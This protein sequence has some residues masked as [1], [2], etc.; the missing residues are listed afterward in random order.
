MDNKF[1]V[2]IL[3]QSIT[4]SLDSVNLLFKVLQELVFLLSQSAD[5]FVESVLN[6]RLLL[7]EKLVELFSAGGRE[8]EVVFCDAAGLDHHL[9]EVGGVLLDDLAYRDRCGVRSETEN[10][11]SSH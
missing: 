2:F 3:V 5:Y 11:Y 6:E 9:A 8:L 7:I 10:T 4:Q 1:L